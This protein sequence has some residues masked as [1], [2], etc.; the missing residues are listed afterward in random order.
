[1]TVAQWRDYRARCGA[2]AT[3]LA[4]GR[5][6]DNEPVVM[7]NWHDA[8]RFCAWLTEAWA[9]HLPPGWGV[10]LPS[11]AEWEKAA[12][13]GEQV[14]ARPMPFALAD[15]VP[16]LQA[17]LAAPGMANPL[18]R[19][20]YPWGDDFDPDRANAQHLVGEPSAVG[21]FAGE[22]SPVGAE[23]LA[24]N[25]WEWTRSLWGKDWAKP[26]FG[27][28]YRVDDARREDASAKDDVLRVVRGGSWLDHADGARCAVRYGLTPGRRLDFLGFRVVLRSSPVSRAAGA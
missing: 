6:R 14:P 3:G 18:P 22:S 27:Y 7:V 21:A 26:D 1:M 24:G 4:A 5:G 25:V 19:R 15:A 8:L 13:G 11:E 17:C 2:D 12:R 28:P 10:S 23:D 20:A 9:Q 16:A